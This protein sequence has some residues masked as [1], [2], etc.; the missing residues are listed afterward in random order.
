MFFHPFFPALSITGEPVISVSHFALTNIRYLQRFRLDI[1]LQ[2][3]VCS[4]L[5]SFVRFSSLS[6]FLFFFYCSAS[7]FVSLRIYLFATESIADGISSGSQWNLQ[8][9]GEFSARFC[10]AL[11][12]IPGARFIALVP[13]VFTKNLV[14][15]EATIK[16][17][18]PHDATPDPPVFP[19]I[20]IAMTSPCDK[21]L[22]VHQFAAS[23]G[24]NQRTS[25]C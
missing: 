17:Q 18:F 15:L 10:R 7:I 13:V 24:Q 14:T 25:T 1:Y 20:C 3:I 22:N 8:E 12:S 19:V 4:I 9:F 5:S 23:A 16:V 6:L 2:A 21:M 11:T